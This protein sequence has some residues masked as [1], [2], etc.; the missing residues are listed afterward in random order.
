MLL[1]LSFV[2]ITYFADYCTLYVV[3][4][5]LLIDATCEN[6]NDRL[7]PINK[8][9][10]L[11]ESVCHVHNRFHQAVSSC[12]RKVFR[13]GIILV[14]DANAPDIHGALFAIWNQL[15]ASLRQ[16]RTNHYNS[17]WL[18]SSYTCY[19]ILLRWLTTVI[20]HHSVAV[21]LQAQNLPV[22]QIIST[23]DFLLSIS[24]CF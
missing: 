1:V 12:T 24:V 11:L 23:L 8:Y 6:P 14:R 15:P 5:D 18:I 10:L 13:V 16:P 19:L 22:P 2:S 17:D 3:Y 4:T 9:I 21:S 7:L 20:I